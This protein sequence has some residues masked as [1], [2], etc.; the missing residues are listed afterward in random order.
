MR[1]RQSKAMLEIL[2]I[3]ELI[4]DDFKDCIAIALRVAADTM[5]RREMKE[6]LLANRGELFDRVEPLHALALHLEEIHGSMR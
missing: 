1:K 2:G 6:R 3:P 5:H 4:A